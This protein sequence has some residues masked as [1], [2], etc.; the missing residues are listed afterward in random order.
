MTENVKKVLDA[1]EKHPYKSRMGAKTQARRLKVSERD[2]KEARKIFSSLPEKKPDVNILILDIETSPMKAWVWRRWKENIYLDQTIQEWFMLSWSG[3][4]LGEDKSFGYV[5]TPEEVASENDY[6]ILVELYK[7]LDK[8]DI[9]VA[10]NGNKFDIPKINTRFLLNNISIPTPYR[11]IDTY[12]VAKKQ[13]GFSS[14]SLDAIAT[15]FGIENKDPHDFQLWK[16]C[17]EGNM[18]SLVRLLNYNKKDVEILEKVY[19][20]L[21][22]WIK[23]HPNINVIANKEDCCPY[24][25]ETH[26]Q[27]VT[28]STYNTQHYKY[29]VYKCD[30]CGAVF[31]SKERVSQKKKYSSI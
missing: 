27:K 15:F 5:L 6:R 7:A 28:N 12:E 2:I 22:P 8:A 1:F 16:E 13:F 31:R 18:E 23:H 24:C 21:R 30:K 25:G 4:W 3:R 14:N 10:H 9:V 26:I 17:M 29:P 19:L 20:K 11:Q